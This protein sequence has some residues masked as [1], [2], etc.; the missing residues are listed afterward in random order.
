MKLRNIQP[1]IDEMPRSSEV[2]TLPDFDASDV[3]LAASAYL[4]FQQ[5]RERGVFSQPLDEKTR[6][7]LQ[8]GV[9][10]I[11]SGLLVITPR[12]YFQPED[13]PISPLVDISALFK[14]NRRLFAYVAIDPTNLYGPRRN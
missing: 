4:Y 14:N 13:N 7:G 2:I 1:E 3:I 12:N 6:L 9:H 8:H 11:N 10:V 5:C